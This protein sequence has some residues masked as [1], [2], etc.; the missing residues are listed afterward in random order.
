MAQ[1]ID[2]NK[3]KDSSLSDGAFDEK[4]PVF[5]NPMRRK[6]QIPSEI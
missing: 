2:L 4:D 3:L 6:L 5:F 1:D